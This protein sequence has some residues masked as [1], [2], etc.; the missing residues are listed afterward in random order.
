MIKYRIECREV[1]SF[2]LFLKKENRFC[3]VKISTRSG[4]FTDLFFLPKIKKTIIKRCKSYEHAK[5]VI[6]NY[7]K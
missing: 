1:P 4:Y 2:P 3:I 7:I 5:K 6:N